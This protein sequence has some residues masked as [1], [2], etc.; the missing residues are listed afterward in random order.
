MLVATEHR[1]NLASYC[2]VKKVTQEVAV[3]AMIGEAL[4][5]AE[6]DPHM[7]QRMERARELKAAL[8]AL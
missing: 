3:N 2:L 1:D 6:Q 7:K 5:L 4:L 8:D